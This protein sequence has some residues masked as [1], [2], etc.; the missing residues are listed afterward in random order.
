MLDAPEVA[1]P[2][3]L[4][5]CSPFADGTAALIICS[6]AVA[7]KCGAVA[8]G[9]EISAC[10]LASGEDPHEKN[11][12]STLTR[13]AQAAYERAGI[14]PRDID[15]AEVHDG[16]V[17]GELYVT[18]ELGF[19]PIGQ[20]GPWAEAGHS[21]LGEASRL[22]FPAVSSPRAIP[23]GLPAQGRWSKFIGTSSRPAR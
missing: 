3:T 20:G 18:E 11:R 12:S 14:G 9:V 19:C 13:L 1:W 8:Q 7:R 10:M 23:S 6:D 15:L 4:P 5:M 21:T 16:T 22:I 17:F 2:L